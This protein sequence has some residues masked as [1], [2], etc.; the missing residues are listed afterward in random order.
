MTNSYPAGIYL[1]K[2]KNRNTRKTCAICSELRIKAQ[3]D[4]TDATVFIVGFEQIN[5]ARENI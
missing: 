4:V 5:G 3:N 2:V 1:F